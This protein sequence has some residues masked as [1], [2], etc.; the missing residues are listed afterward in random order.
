MGGE[1]RDEID[2]VQAVLPPPFCP[3]PFCPVLPESTVRAIDLRYLERWEH[4]HTRRLDPLPLAADQ[5]AT[6]EIVQRLL[7]PLLAEP[8]RPARLQIAHHRQ[9]LVLTCPCKIGRAHV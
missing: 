9:K 3:D 1:R 4:V 6:K 8:Q 5:L 2:A 7:L